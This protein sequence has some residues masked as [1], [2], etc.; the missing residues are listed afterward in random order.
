V[1]VAWLDRLLRRLGMLAYRLG[2]ARPIMWLNR[3]AP[4]VLLYHACLSRE[5][6]YIAGLAANTTPE[7]F[8]RHMAFVRSHYRV[9]P[10]ALL[11]T[12]PLPPYA[13]AITFDDGYRSVYLNAFPVLKSL[14]LPAT[15]YAVTDCL[16]GDRMV[17]VNELNY[18][19]RRHPEVSGPLACEALG[20]PPHS[21]PEELI[22]R[23]RVEYDG[24]RVS[25]LLDRIRG[26]LANGAAGDRIHISWEEAAEMA[27]AGVTFGSHTASHPNLARLDREAVRQELERSRKALAEGLAT[28]TSLAWP[29]GS[30][31][32]AAASVALEVGFRSLMEVGGSNRPL[33]LARVGRVPVSAR[34]EAE[35]FAELEVVAPLRGWVRRRLGR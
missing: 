33:D 9:I 4:R 3:N 28:A 29:F 18:Y 13:A 25:A 2:L 8:A 31:S 32:A 12:G 27:Q 1:S 14:G 34:S 26:A 19:L 5:D 23:A 7:V 6:D 35:L 17:W 22:E 24:E 15:V 30:R 10:L 21:R 16:S 11:E 20:C